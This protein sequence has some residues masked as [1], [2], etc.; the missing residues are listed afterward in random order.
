MTQPNYESKWWGYI[1]DQMM[2]QNLQHELDAHHQFYR[3][4]L[5]HVKGSILECACGTGLFLLPLLDIGHNMFGFDISLS[6]S[7]RL[8][9][10]AEAQGVVDINHRVSLQEFVSFRYEQKFDAI[11]IPTNTFL[12]LT[13]QE[14]QITTLRNIY[15]HLALGGR[16]LLDLQ[17]AGVRELAEH[18]EIIQGR[19]Y[20]WVHPETGLPIRQRIKSRLDFNNQLTLDHCYIEYEDEREDFPMHVRW[21]YKEEFHLL[22]RLAGFTDWACCGSPSGEPLN[23]GPNDQHSYWIINKR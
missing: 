8:K 14:A 10:K 17:L 20:T 16:L 13:T 22:L 2:T 19:W 23:L 5:Q 7:A 18:P 4:N 21:M 11:T 3:E 12:I 15:K 6:M 9:A 1:Y